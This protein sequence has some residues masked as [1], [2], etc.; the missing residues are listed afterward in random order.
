MASSLFISHQVLATENYNTGDPAEHYDGRYSPNQHRCESELLK[1]V[2]QRIETA[3]KLYDNL[4]TL[5]STEVFLNAIPM[6]SV[7]YRV[8]SRRDRFNIIKPSGGI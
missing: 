6:A 7:E 2:R 3:Q 4:D 1:M 5:R 8:A